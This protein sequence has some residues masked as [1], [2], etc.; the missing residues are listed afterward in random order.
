MLSANMQPSIARCSM[1]FDVTKL[2]S[3]RLLTASK[4][5]ALN[6]GMQVAEVQLSPECLAGVRVVAHIAP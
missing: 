6:L 2:H 4:G 3:S 5:L 1:Q